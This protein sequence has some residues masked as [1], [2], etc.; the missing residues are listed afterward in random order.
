VLPASGHGD[1]EIWLQDALAEVSVSSVRVLLNQTPM[2]TFVTVNRLPRGVRVI[3]K[4]GASLNADFAFHPDMDNLI[5]FSAADA[6]NVTYR[7]QFYVVLSQQAHAAMLAPKVAARPPVQE[8]AS[9]AQ[10]YPPTITLTSAWPEKTASRVLTLDVTVEDREGLRR[11]MIE[12][13]SSTVEEVILENEQPVRKQRGFIAKGKLPGT[14]AGSGRSLHIAIPITL[15][16]R[17]NTVGV[18]AENGAGLSAY[19]DH[20]I[21]L[22]TAR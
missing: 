5:A 15:D 16:K 12:V 4:M 2:A 22:T 11:V 21:E 1:V 8:V 19:A 14:V 9:P 20:T 7:A 17:L 6:S 10:V 18:R 3:V 13:N